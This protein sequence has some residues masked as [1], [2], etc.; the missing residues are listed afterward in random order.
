MV[1]ASGDD[2]AVR[3]FFLSRMV[4]SEGAHV[5]CLRHEVRRYLNW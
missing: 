4:F 1:A 2:K 5:K 3:D